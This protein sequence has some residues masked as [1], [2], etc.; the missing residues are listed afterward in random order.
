MRVF[1]RRVHIEVY[2]FEGG[3]RLERQAESD[4]RTHLIANPKQAKRVWE[5]LEHFFSRVDQHGVRV[6]A[7][8][9]RAVLA[10]DGLMLKSPPDYT[11]DIALLSDLT[12]RNLS[13]LKEHTTLRFGLKPADSVHIPRT[14]EL[15][16]LLAAA[17]SGHHLITG[18]PGCGKSGLIH[19]LVETLG[20]D[21]LPV[22]LLL[23]EEVFGRDW[24]GSANLPGLKYALDDVLANRPDGRRGFLIT[25]ALDALRDV[26]MQ[27]LLR[28]L[29]HDV[30][31]GQ[32]D[33]TIVASVREFDLKHSR[34][35]REIFTDER[36]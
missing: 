12:K 24:K 4:I 11:D 3:Q 9:L 14:E 18:E 26:E 31:E 13:R 32:S 16:A 33:W 7:A 28:R 36:V 1:L 15:S 27:K 25:D 20:R 21:G 10:S 30:K 29:L 17:K 19:S 23:A 35:L 8:S 6:T 34:E 5:K 2:E 22:V